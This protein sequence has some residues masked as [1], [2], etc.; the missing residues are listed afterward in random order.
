MSTDRVFF[1]VFG[2]PAPAGSKRHVGGG[3]IVDASKRSTPWK[4][5]IRQVAGRAME[6]RELL[7]GAL[8]VRF[9]FIVARPKGHFGKKG[10]RPSAP[11]YPTVKPDLLKLARAVEDALTGI[12]YHDDAQI[13]YE[14]LC[15]KYGE[16]EHVKVTVS[17]LEGEG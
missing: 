1:T 8:V 11:A 6:G 10:L 13:A 9:E 3:R 4:A 14:V 17:A 15:K 2:K 16:T 12:V 5:E 7:R